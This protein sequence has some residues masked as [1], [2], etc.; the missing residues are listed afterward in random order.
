MSLRP[1]AFLS[2]LSFFILSPFSTAK[3]DDT[4]I[5]TILLNHVDKGEFYIMMRDDGD[6]FIRT[7]D[8]KDMGF[9]DP[10]GTVY[11]IDDEPYLLLST[12]TGVE[13]QLDEATLNLEITAIPSHFPKQVFDI[14]R[15]RPADVRF[16]T[17]S[18]GFLNYSIE[19]TKTSSA[20]GLY[21]LTNELGIRHG[22][23]LFLTDSIYS[24][25]DIEDPFVRLMTSIT[26]DL[27]QATQRI[28]V[29]DFILPPDNFNS[30]LNLGGI[31]FQKAYQTDPY[32]ITH[33][34][35]DLSGS[36]TLPSE[37]EIYMDGNLFL[38][39]D[40]SP[41][42]FDL[43]N[44]FP[45]EGAGLME[46]VIRDPL[47]REER[48][49]NPFYLTTAL[50]KKGFHDYSYSMGFVREDFGIK[51]FEYGDLALSG[52][53]L[54]GLH[55]FITIIFN[56]EASKKRYNL[57]PSAIFRLWNAGVVSL[58]LATSQNADGDQGM[59]GSL[60]YIYQTRKFNAQWLGRG[61]SRDYAGILSNPTPESTQLS[62]LV[63]FA[64]NTKRLGT[65]GLDHGMTKRHDGTSEQTITGRYSQTIFK[66][67]RLISLFRRT[68]NGS[69][70]I[71]EFFIS[72]IYSPTRNT[73]LSTRFSQ[74]GDT[75]KETIQIQKDPPVGEGFGARATYERMDSGTDSTNTY[76]TFLQYNAKYGNYIGR[77]H[78]VD[79]QQTIQ[80]S[81][82]G[83]IA[84]IGRRVYF[85]RPVTDSF[86]LVEVSDLNNVRVYLNNNE[87]G[88]T[89]SSGRILIPNM[90]SYYYNQVSIDNHDIP[91]DYSFPK[92]THIISPAERSGTVIKIEV[93]KLRAIYGKI[94][95]RTAGEE[96]PLE[97]YELRMTAGE[98]E[99]IF[100]TTSAGE[101]YIEDIEPG[102]YE[103]SFIYMEK[104]CSF[105][106]IVPETEESLMDLGE[107]FCEE[108]E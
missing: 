69:E 27:R 77:Y 101:F 51:S 88:K 67:V 61:F 60:T 70:N 103:A 48:L 1:F 59:A 53:H 31:R 35:L 5:L 34:L 58:A 19:Y 85:G 41:G 14:L 54:Y 72:L 74:V 16:S 75:N 83:G 95:I 4:V 99:V 36:V 68:N 10:K 22:N 39:E 100:Q 73:T 57:G 65:L 32:L 21:D 17:E 102:Q 6:F 3:G 50:L 96:Q 106:I 29:G 28:I 105:D 30:N 9:K 8:L 26:Y 20:S 79:D 52:F 66:G 107:L 12:M 108:M 98:E 42:E 56:T 93:S 33:P 86:A 45:R 94:Y 78:T 25:G 82:A 46:I 104:P 44:I 76:D 64:Y 55:D 38:S 2:L 90:A 91:I 84:Y 89:D 13:F 37:L 92:L 62:S 81:A 18:S 15:P 23:S 40:L 24:S 47:G 80:A 71:N 43:R 49:Q 97:S 7:E 87:I 11:E 63:G